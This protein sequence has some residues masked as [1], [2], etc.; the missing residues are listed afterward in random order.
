MAPCRYFFCA[1]PS[2]IAASWRV[3]QASDMS[4][5]V[6]RPAHGGSITMTPQAFERTSQ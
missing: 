4:H 5:E 1:E 6:R 2:D 3:G